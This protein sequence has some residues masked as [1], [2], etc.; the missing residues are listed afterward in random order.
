MMAGDVHRNARALRQ[1]GALAA[2]GMSV[3]VL[4]LPGQATSPLPDGVSVEP[5]AVQGSGGPGFFRRLH[6]QFAEAAAA[7]AAKLVH[8]S[9]LYVLRAARQTAR[10]RGV[11]YTFDAREL[12]THVA[13]TAGR[14]HVRFFW[15]VVQRGAIRQAAR[16][17]TVSNHIADFLAERY[18]ITRPDVQLNAP[19]FREI[20]PDPFLRNTLGLMPDQPILLHLGQLR[21]D[22]GAEV[23]IQAMAEWPTTAPDAQLVFLG[24]GPHRKTLERL[25]NGL[26]RVHFLDPVPPNRVLPVTA[27][28][29]LGVTLLQPTCLN[30]RYALPNKLFDYLAAGLPVVASD[31]EETGAMVRRFDCG[32]TVEPNRPDAVRDALLKACTRSADT[33]R[34]KRNARV[35]G[36]TLDWN[37]VS[38][39]FAR[40]MRSLIP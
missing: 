40:Q 5:I 37:A 18:G 1:L 32:L 11:P 22:R 34:W 19:A 38:D 13:A 26:A 17:W 23:L 6:R 4:C 36:E 20:T 7:H 29:D 12:Y 28:A 10:A 24:Y 30:H 15:D 33:L 35:A 31:L 3:R 25:A 39:R 21:R 2:D 14:P 16:V 27:G 9:D 8:A